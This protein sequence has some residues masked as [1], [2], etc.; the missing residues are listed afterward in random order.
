VIRY[1]VVSAP[2]T[3]GDTDRV[4][5]D[6]DTADQALAKCPPRFVVRESPHVKGDRWLRV[7]E[8]TSPLVERRARRGS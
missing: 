3:Y 6:Y 5:G 4:Y 1:V 2:G 8:Q 7:Y